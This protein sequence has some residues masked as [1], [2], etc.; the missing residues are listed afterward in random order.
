[1]RGEGILAYL[2]RDGRQRL[3]AT[4]LAGT[5]A[6]QLLQLVSSRDYFR[7]QHTTYA[8]WGDP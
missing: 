7:N 1:M 3:L 8:G 5:G 6:K 2:L 4:A